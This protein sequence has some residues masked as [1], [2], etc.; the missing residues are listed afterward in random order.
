MGRQPA[1][2]CQSKEEQIDEEKTPLLIKSVAASTMVAEPTSLLSTIFRT[3]SLSCLYIAVS[4]GMIIFNKYLMRADRFPYATILTTLHMSN[5]LLM[6]T[7]LFWICPALF[8]TAH[9]VF[10]EPQN[11][12]R[13]AELAQ[14]L[15]PFS[16]I[17]GCGALS[18]VAGNCAY[19]FSSVAFLQM[20]KES[21]IIFVYT[22]MVIVGL[23]SLKLRNVCVLAFIAVSAA[24]AVYGDVIFSVMGLS[25]QMFAGVC[26][27]AQVVLTNLL[28]SRSTGPRLDPMTMVL[29][30]APMMLLFLVPASVYFWD[31]QIIVQ[32]RTW[33]PL[34][35]ANMALAFL[36]QITTAVT[37]RGISA[38]GHALASVL[39][40]MAIVGAAGLIL[41]EPL[42]LMQVGGFVSTIFGISLYSALKLF[43]NMRLCPCFG[44]QELSP[45]DKP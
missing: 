40:D 18:L 1:P 5:S 2:P 23:D 39:K 45:E 4:A 26:G 14:A 36:L 37:I 30:T 9:H 38:T 22:M 32:V 24:V 31:A 28:M 16:L 33:W 3:V 35:C 8:P 25:L 34:I 7:C 21:H 13:P 42:S 19:K 11:R 12:K 10:G 15:S 20:V 6:S 41:R 43:P 27:S 29:C 44:Q 17:A